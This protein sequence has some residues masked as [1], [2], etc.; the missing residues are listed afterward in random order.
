MKKG[1]VI[2]LMV[3]AIIIVIG[4]TLSLFASF[5]A[6]TLV[7][8]GVLLGCSI[9]EFIEY[10]FN[11]DKKDAIFMS[12]ASLIG[13][14]LVALT[15]DNLEL[16]LAVAML[17]FTV[18]SCFIKIYGLKYINIKRTKLF[19]MRYIVIGVFTLLG[20]LV[21]IGVYYEI[22][23]KTYLVSLLFMCF[24]LQELF[25]DILI[26]INEIKEVFKG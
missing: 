6:P 18:F 15:K 16:T 22:L 17:A 20:V 7:Y 12:L 25:C 5:F 23:P 4:L 8:A 1:H 26:H 9:L 13:F 19:S 2:E 10:I 11:K 3:D 14:I 21:S 24:G